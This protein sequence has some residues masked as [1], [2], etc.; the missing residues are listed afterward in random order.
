[1]TYG[2]AL[3]LARDAGFVESNPTLD[4]DGW[5]SL[6][7]LVIIGVHAFGIYVDLNGCSPT[8]YPT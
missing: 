4:L 8:A 6:F 2:D 1:M 3:Q 5:D 7:K